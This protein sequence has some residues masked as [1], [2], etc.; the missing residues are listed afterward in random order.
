MARVR[1]ADVR[2]LVPYAQGARSQQ[3]VVSSTEQMSADP[4]Q[5][6]DD[7][8]HRGEPLQLGG[9]L[10]SSHLLVAAEQRLLT[11]RIVGAR[12]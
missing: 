4:E 5:I 9:R 2:H 11:D 7:A 10:E 6:L 3:T 1:S 12:T 8:V